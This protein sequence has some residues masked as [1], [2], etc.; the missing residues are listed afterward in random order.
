MFIIL[1]MKK[2]IG[3]FLN[4]FAIRYSFI[5]FF[6]ESIQNITGSFAENKKK[7]MF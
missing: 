1:I 7:I 3:V 6:G 2:I 5:L 4:E